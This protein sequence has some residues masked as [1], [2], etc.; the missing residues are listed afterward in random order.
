MKV[1]TTFW[2]K[3]SDVQGLLDSELSVAIPSAS[4]MA[5]TGYF[6]PLHTRSPVPSSQSRDRRPIISLFAVMHENRTSSWVIF[7]VMRRA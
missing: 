5:S 1:V 7:S 2:R 4:E 6:H 3:Q